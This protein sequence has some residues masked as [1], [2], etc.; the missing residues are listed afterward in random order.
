[1]ILTEQDKADIVAGLKEALSSDNPGFVRQELCDERSG[2]LH[3]MLGVQDKKMDKQTVLMR[4]LYAPVL[5][6]A[7]KALWDV[8]SN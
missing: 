3:A 6:I 7:F 4:W 1:M 2:N 5:G 8:I